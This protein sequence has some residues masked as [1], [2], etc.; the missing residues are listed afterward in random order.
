MV[1]TDTRPHS[2]HTLAPAPGRLTDT[3]LTT[4]PLYVV[5]GPWGRVCVRPMASEFKKENG[6]EC[7]PTETVA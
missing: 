5:K 3:R 2:P 7:Q 4:G 1:K 6:G